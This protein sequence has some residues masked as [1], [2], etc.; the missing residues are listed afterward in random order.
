M[1]DN[2]LTLQ[3][4]IVNIGSLTHLITGRVLKALSDGGVDVYAVAASIWL[5]KQFKMRSALERTVHSHLASRKGIN[6]FLAKALH[7]GWG[8]SEVAVEMSRTRAGTNALLL[9]GAISAGS[10]YFEAARCLSEL[11]AISGCEPDHLPNVDVLKS[12]MYQN[13]LCYLYD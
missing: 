8:H 13:K 2:S 12:G 3:A 1:P 11:L 5:G 4:D 10:S 7:I 9:I 6:G